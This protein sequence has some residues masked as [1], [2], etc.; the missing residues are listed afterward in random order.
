MKEF[1]GKHELNEHLLLLAEFDLKE[2]M[3]GFH[4]SFIERQAVYQKFLNWRQN[5]Y[6]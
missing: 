5:D 2:Q 1:R 3:P 6:L 4:F